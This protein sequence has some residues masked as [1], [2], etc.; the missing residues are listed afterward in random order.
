MSTGLIITL[1]VIAAVV[2]VGVGLWV[3]LRR[4][5]VRERPLAV[6]ERARFEARWTAVQERFVDSP[7]EAV[8]EAD[9]LLGEVAVA[10]GYPDGERYE[11]Q[12]DALSVRHAR[13]LDAYRHVHRMAREGEPGTEEMRAAMVEA[14]ALFEELVRPSRHDR[15][16]RTPAARPH[17]PGAFNRRHPKES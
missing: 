14:R 3:A 8:G 13:H 12:L 9:R 6:A 11:Q 1:I 7:R 5:R 15:D 16:R 17:L 10:R 2:V 4:R